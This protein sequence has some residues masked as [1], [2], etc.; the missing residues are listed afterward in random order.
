MPEA[1]VETAVE[2]ASNQS[3]PGEPRVPCVPA[4]FGPVGRSRPASTIL[5]VGDSASAQQE[6]PRLRSSDELCLERSVRSRKS[7]KTEAPDLRINNH[8]RLHTTFM[9]TLALDS[10]SAF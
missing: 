2:A 5:L 8:K 9:T 10:P 1:V 4:S 6:P 7:D 3:R